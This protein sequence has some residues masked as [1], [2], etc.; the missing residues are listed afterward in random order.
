MH[1]DVKYKK[2]IFC[3]ILLSVVIAMGLW[4]RGCL[5]VDDCLDSGGRWNYETKLCEL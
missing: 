5:I 3:L 4:L 1:I 2:L